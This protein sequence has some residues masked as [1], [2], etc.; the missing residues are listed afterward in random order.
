MS[1]CHVCE[2]SI[3]K[4]SSE[5]GSCRKTLQPS[6]LSKCCALSIQT[7]KEIMCD[8]CSIVHGP[9]TVS[10]E[11]DTAAAG[12]VS[13]CE[14]N[15]AL[16][17][18]VMC[19]HLCACLQYWSSCVDWFLDVRMSF[20]VADLSTF[21]KRLPASLRPQD[22]LG[23]RLRSNPRPCRPQQ[24]VLG[25]RTLTS[26]HTLL[27]VESVEWMPECF[28]APLVCMSCK[29]SR[30][31]TACT[32]SSGSVKSLA[33][34]SSVSLATDFLLSSCASGDPTT[35]CVVV[36]C[37][38]AA[39]SPC[40]LVSTLATC[41]LIRSISNRVSCW[42]SFCLSFLVAVFECQPL[43]DTLHQLPFEIPQWRLFN[44]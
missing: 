41:V 27:K 36:T 20:V 16:S 34:M 26:S 28:V 38:C 7:M 12:P 35:C 32:G 19:D 10:P 25:C 44:P 30:F 21:V 3:R 6:T 9:S 33:A 24:S 31:N 4:S 18:V 14:N 43:A 22:R 39:T 2:V 17:D 5:S 42:T 13:S 1:A 15:N 8:A 23:S 29:I 37:A 40:V 11:S